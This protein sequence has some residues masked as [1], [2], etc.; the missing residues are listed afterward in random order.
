MR[1]WL[2]RMPE[3]MRDFASY[4]PPP[5]QRGQEIASVLLDGLSIDDSALCVIE[6]RLRWPIDITLDP[7]RIVLPSNNT[8][9]GGLVKGTQIGIQIS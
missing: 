4:G 6:G 8:L 5:D 2:T 9:S 7:T 1:E 3:H